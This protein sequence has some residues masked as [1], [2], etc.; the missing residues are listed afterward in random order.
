MLISIPCTLCNLSLPGYLTTTITPFFNNVSIINAFRPSLVPSRFDHD[1]IERNLKTPST[2]CHLDGQRPTTWKGGRKT[3]ENA[4]LPTAPT[5]GHRHTPKHCN[6]TTYRRPCPSLHTI[7]SPTSV[8]DTILKSSTSP[9]T[10]EGTL[11]CDSTL[12]SNRRRNWT[13]LHCT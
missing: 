7:T 13:V 5:H 8:V 10:T 11:H 12:H 9:H 3:S 2:R 1:C 4:D 6:A